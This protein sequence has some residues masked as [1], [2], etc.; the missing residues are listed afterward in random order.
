ME[1]S[2]GS[3][4]ELSKIVDRREMKYGFCVSVSENYFFLFNS[5][6]RTHYDN[7]PI[8]KKGRNFPVKDCFLGCGHLFSPSSEQ[9]G[10]KV[11]KLEIREIREIIEKVKVSALLTPIQIEQVTKSLEAF[12]NG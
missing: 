11:G 10:D 1:I 8:Y 5:E 6:N 12:A 4:Y 7:L 9:V 3:I 2:V